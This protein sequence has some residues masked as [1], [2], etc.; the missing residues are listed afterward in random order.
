MQHTEQRTLR[1]LMETELSFTALTHK[2]AAL[3]PLACLASEEDR[4]GEQRGIGIGSLTYKVASHDAKGGL[5]ILEI[6][7][8]A[9]GGPARHLH[10]DQE[11]WFY[12]VA[13]EFIV[14]IG[15]E[16]MRLRPGDSVLVPRKTPHVWACAGAPARLLIVFTP[17][18]E[19]EGFFDEI[20]RANALAPQDPELW[21]RYGM[22]LLGPPLAVE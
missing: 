17:A 1:A 11:E 20:S 6:L 18:G 2:P 5:F 16:R 14:E 3:A 21:R 4:Y 12:A 10:V 22:E 7:L 9:K 19:M 15:G 8:H 13:G